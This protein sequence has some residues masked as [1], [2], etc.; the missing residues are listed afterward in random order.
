MIAECYLSDFVKSSKIVLTSHP[1]PTPSVSTISIKK[2][3][4]TTNQDAQKSGYTF[5][6]YIEK[7]IMYLLLQLWQSTLRLWQIYVTVETSHTSIEV[8]NSNIFLST[9]IRIYISNIC[10]CIRIYQLP[11]ILLPMFFFDVFV[12]LRIRGMW[13]SYWDSYRTSFFVS[14]CYW[15]YYVF[16]LISKSF[17]YFACTL[18]CHSYPNMRSIQHHACVFNARLGFPQ[19][20]ECWILMDTQASNFIKLRNPTSLVWRI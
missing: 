2:C 9:S 5:A 1:I 3:V 11:P 20:V 8:P 13:T 19:K 4:S 15:L 10:F 7:L 16:F 14:L 12:F 18:G 17:S 6:N